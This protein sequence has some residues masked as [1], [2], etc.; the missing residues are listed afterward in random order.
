M[1]DKWI[2]PLLLMLCVDGCHAPAPA[3]L[4]SE[5]DSEP[6]TGMEKVTLEILG[7]P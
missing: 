7:L 6:E 4:Q 2:L 1:P 5:L 3:L